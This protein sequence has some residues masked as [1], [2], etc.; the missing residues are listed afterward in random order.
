MA[1][2]V[3]FEVKKTTGATA[4]KKQSRKKKAK[5]D[6]DEYAVAIMLY[7]A[8]GLFEKK[9]VEQSEKDA[10][11]RVQKEYNHGE[12]KLVSLDQAFRSMDHYAKDSNAWRKTWQATM[13]FVHK[14]NSDP[15]FLKQILDEGGAD[16]KSLDD[17]LKGTN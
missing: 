16:K 3:K 15:A 7:H 8:L 10:V 14:G 2:M 4:K 13:E 1:R 12:D 5:Y 9:D 17:W 6:F 11:E